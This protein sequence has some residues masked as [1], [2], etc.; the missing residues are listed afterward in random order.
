[1][2]FRI[3]IQANKTVSQFHPLFQKT[4]SIF[5]E[6]EE[7]ILFLV[8]HVVDYP[9]K[10]KKHQVVGTFGEMEASQKTSSRQNLI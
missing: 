10:T 9:Y 6:E 3:K 8:I 5:F 4:K 1:M 2:M 7:E